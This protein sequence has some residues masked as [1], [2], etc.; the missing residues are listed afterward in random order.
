MVPVSSCFLFVTFAHLEKEATH[1][2]GFQTALVDLEV[3]CKTNFP[4]DH[5][6]S[7]CLSSVLQTP[8]ITETYLSRLIS[9]NSVYIHI[10]VSA[11]YCDSGVEM[12]A[13]V[14]SVQVKCDFGDTGFPGFVK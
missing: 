11:A 2:I 7:H 13:E 12:P 1:V 5:S 4:L 3:H 9:L 14:L 6:G 8:K 10:V